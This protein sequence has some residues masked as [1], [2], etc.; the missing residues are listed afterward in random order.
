MGIILDTSVLIT[1]E[2]IN[3]GPSQ[4]LESIQST[5]GDV[6]VGISVVTVAEM[7][8]GAYRAQTES[9]KQ[10]RLAF[11]GQLT[12]AVPVHPMTIE[13]AYLAGRIQAE[14]MAK[15]IQLSFEDLVIGSTALSLGYAVLTHNLRDFQRLPGLTVLQG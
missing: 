5:A 3:Q 1:S 14:E 2:R 8:H 7:V 12:G 15:G 10:R 4:I 13:I 11:V 6:A 9:Q